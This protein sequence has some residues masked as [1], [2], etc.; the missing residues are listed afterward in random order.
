MLL[1]E[2]PSFI[3]ENYINTKAKLDQQPTSDIFEELDNQQLQDYRYNNSLKLQKQLKQN[4]N[5]FDEERQLASMSL[6]QLYEITTFY[7]ENNNNN[8]RE[9]ASSA[10]ATITVYSDYTKLR[11]KELL[12]ISIA[13]LQQQISE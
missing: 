1:G 12:D 9:T 13:Y 6:K 7:E 11:A 5:I 2:H 10:S 8:D 4:K 3:D